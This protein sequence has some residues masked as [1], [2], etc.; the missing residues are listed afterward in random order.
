MSSCP[1]CGGVI[2]RDCFNP[3]ECAWISQQQANQ[4]EAAQYNAKK[5]HRS[6]QQLKADIL[7]I[8]AQALVHCTNYNREAAIELLNKLT[9]KLSAV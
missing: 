1:G 4:C 7:P 5:T 3:E 9:A 8:A 6:L 2:G